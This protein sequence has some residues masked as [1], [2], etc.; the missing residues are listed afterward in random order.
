MLRGPFLAIALVVLV[1]LVAL[2]RGRAAGDLAPSA[3]SAPPA[4]AGFSPYVPPRAYAWGECR[5]RVGPGYDGAR[6]GRADWRVLGAGEV[7]CAGRHDRIGIAVRE[8]RAGGGQ[9]VVVA[10]AA[11]QERRAASTVAAR[12]APVCRITPVARWETQVL[13]TVD[14]RASGWLGGGWSGP[15]ADGCGPRRPTG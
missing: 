7:D 6:A 8:L 3:R 13:V 9:P 12:T 14:G 11:A 15:R 5:I 4:T 10:A 1:A 2:G